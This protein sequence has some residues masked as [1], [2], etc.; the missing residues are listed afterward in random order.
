MI[1]SVQEYKKA[2][3]YMISPAALLNLTANAGGVG[4]S[5]SECAC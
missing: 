2:M 4:V 1:N 3:Y 5:W